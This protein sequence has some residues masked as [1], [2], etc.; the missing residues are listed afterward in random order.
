MKQVSGN[1]WFT[2]EKDETRI[3]FTRSFI[4]ERLSE[5][6]HVL[7]AD[8]KNVKEKGPLLVL[9]TND[10][11]EPVCSPVT[12]RLTYFN[13][14]ARNFPDRLTEEDCIVSLSSKELKKVAKTMF[15]DE[16]YQGLVNNIN[17]QQ[18]NFNQV[19][20]NVPPAGAWNV[21][22]QAQAA[23]P[24][25]QEVARVHPPMPELVREPRAPQREPGEP[26]AT[27]NARIHVWMRTRDEIR[28]I[29]QDRVALHARQMQ[30]H[31]DAEHAQRIAA[32][33]QQRVIR[34]PVRN[35]APRNAWHDDLEAE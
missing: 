3:G 23:P 10:G 21:G 8:T 15:V 12:G 2:T 24:M 19:N 13:E 7:P 9:E 28:Q 35:V 33:P 31:L 27:W 20:F 6:F 17:A 11:L 4:A 22:V 16:S 26:I 34:N 5:C 29:N 30:I 18:F 1:L 14:K 25:P 32:V